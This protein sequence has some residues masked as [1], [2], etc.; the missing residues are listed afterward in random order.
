MDKNLQRYW[1]LLALYAEQRCSPA[2]RRELETLIRDSWDQSPMDHSAPEVDWSMVYARIHPQVRQS[3]PR[4][5]GWRRMI[6]A[7]AV[8]ILFLGGTWLYRRSAPLNVTA[9]G[10]Q[11][12]RFH[13][14]IAAGG[15]KAVLTLAGGQ[16]L[17]LDSLVNGEIARQGGASIHK[18]VDGEIIYSGVVPSNEALSYN[19]L[20]TPRGGKYQL[21]LPDG[22]K[23][24][25]NAASSIT[26]PVAFRGAERKVSITGEAY[27]EVAANKSRP[28]QV[29]M[30]KGVTTEVLGTTFD[31][32]V[33][34]DEP[35]LKTTLVEGAVN[36]RTAAGTKLLQ[37][38][39]E[40]E[41]TRQGKVVTTVT[42]VNTE[43]TTA[44]I[45]DEFFFQKTNIEEMMRQIARWYD[46]EV[47][48]QGKPKT[49]FVGS[50]PRSISAASLFKVLEATGGVHFII[51][52]KKITVMP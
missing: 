5:M 35:V 30:G 27:F 26:Y 47:V 11:K 45:R 40:A 15:N 46:V 43:N 52:G 31:I 51:E 12:E 10:S 2:E 42:S 44:W 37:P 50:I 9:T 17:V 34:S 32:N 3:L 1:D 36:V 14:D 25:L 24:W 4:R 6:A 49:Q 33:Y 19:T 29:D 38:G 16:K 8:L 20:S 23:V 7:A 18:K 28:F 21:T 22:T 13:N 48:Y 39:Q 41:I